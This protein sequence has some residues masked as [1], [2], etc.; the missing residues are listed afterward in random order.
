MAQEPNEPRPSSDILPEPRLP[1]VF[2]QIDRRVFRV[3]Y[4]GTRNRVFNVL[5]PALSIIA[6]RGAIHIIIGALL[7]GFGSA[8]VQQAGLIML[9]AAMGAGLLAEGTIKF[10]WKRR[11]PFQVMADV[12]PLVPAQRL[13]RRPSFPSG[14]SAGYMAA[15]VASIASRP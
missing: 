11:R 15:A 8:R 1:G 9:T 12:Q 2:E 5:M 10:V 6:N 14:H 3:L 13:R 4:F 7:I